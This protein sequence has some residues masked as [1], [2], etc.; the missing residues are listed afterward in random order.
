MTSD[1]RFGA[2]LRRLVDEVVRILGA[3][4]ADCWVFD[5]ERR[6]LRCQAVVG[7]PERNV[8][9]ELARPGPSSR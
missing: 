1:L 9:R 4:A 6:M 3:D 5:E 2:V 7:V 8:G